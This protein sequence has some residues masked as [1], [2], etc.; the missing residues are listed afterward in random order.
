MNVLSCNL[1]SSLL[2]IITAYGRDWYEH[3]RGIYFEVNQ[4]EMT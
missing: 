2:N 4:P 1:K 3:L